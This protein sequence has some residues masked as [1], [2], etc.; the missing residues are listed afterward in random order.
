MRKNYKL[1]NRK[2]EVTK[3]LLVLLLIA[4]RTA[5]TYEIEAGSKVWNFDGFLNEIVNNSEAKADIKNEGTITNKTATILLNS[6]KIDSKVNKIG[7]KGIMMADAAGVINNSQT[8]MDS[9]AFEN[10]TYFIGE[11]NN[12][13]RME[14]KNITAQNYTGNGSIINNS[15]RL[16]NGNNRS[17]EYIV[18]TGPVYNKGNM[19]GI[20]RTG[21]EAGGTGNGINNSLSI[22]YSKLSKASLKKL[23][24]SGI[25]EVGM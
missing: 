23:D 11:V 1:L 2:I 5:Y 19:S 15:L 8:V 4:G 24:N 22:L 9:L 20:T 18:E 12:E 16:L 13:G 6:G 17:G 25:I 3:A 21:S 10:M 14:A 7:N